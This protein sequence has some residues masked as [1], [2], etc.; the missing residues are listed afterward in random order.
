MPYDPIKGQG[1]GG[2]KLPKVANFKVSPLL[3]CMQS[4]D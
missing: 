2:L 3:V 4:K 1:Q